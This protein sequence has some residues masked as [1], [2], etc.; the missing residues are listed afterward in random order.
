M[1]EYNV[2]GLCLK[3]GRLR[4]AID[5]CVKQS[6]IFRQIIQYEMATNMRQDESA[7]LENLPVERTVPFHFLPKRL[8][9]SHLSVYFFVF[10][11]MVFLLWCPQ[12]AT[13][14]SSYMTLEKSYY[15]LSYLLSTRSMGIM[16][17]SIWCSDFLII[18]VEPG[19]EEY[20]WG[21]PY[22]STNSQWKERPVPFSFLPQKKNRFFLTKG[23][24]PWPSHWP[25]SRDLVT[26][27]RTKKAREN[28]P[29]GSKSTVIEVTSIWHKKTRPTQRKVW[30]RWCVRV[31]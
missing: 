4:K 21:I 13:P 30:G 28:S 18:P 31:K 6:R 5:V 27:K 10:S 20:L 29:D 26:T 14:C 24:H 8:R 22:F 11:F 7:P 12:S 15:L 17:K 2:E 25:F 9:I 23:K 19:R 1:N 3:S 16:W